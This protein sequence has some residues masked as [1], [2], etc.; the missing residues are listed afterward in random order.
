MSKIEQRIQ[1]YIFGCIAA[2]A[3]LVFVILL[4]SA[5][6]SNE[7]KFAIKQLKMEQLMQQESQKRN[8][9]V[10]HQ[11]FPLPEL[12][13]LFD[14]WDTIMVHKN[15]LLEEQQKSADQNLTIGLTV[16]AAICTILPVVLGISQTFNFK[17]QLDEAKTEMKRQLD[18][19]NKKMSDL[20]NKQIIYNLRSFVNTMSMNIKTLIDLQELEINKN[21]FLTSKE[22][23]KLELDKMVDSSCECQKE[24]LK[25]KN[26]LQDIEGETADEIMKSIQHNALEIFLLQNSLLRKYEVFFSGISL[27]ELQSLVN[28][29]YSYSEPLILYPKKYENLEDCFVYAL[30]I[31]KQIQTLFKGQ[32]D[33]SEIT[34]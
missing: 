14:K 7:R 34:K 24:Y 15:D 29:I 19:A 1:K 4:Y 9:I 32:V 23:I 25:I 21:P 12:Y 6:C 5:Y 17:I 10:T 16:I 26:E 20:Q 8:E 28:I 2:F 22:L 30:T 3:I 31:S 13:D 18:E 27:I 11:E 33:H